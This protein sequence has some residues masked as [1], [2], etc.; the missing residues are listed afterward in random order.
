MKNLIILAKT[1]QKSD[2]PVERRVHSVTSVTARHSDA[3]Y[4]FTFYFLT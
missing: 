3:F 1:K 4:I 2:N